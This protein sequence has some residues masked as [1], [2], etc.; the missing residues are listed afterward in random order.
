MRQ[1]LSAHALVFTIAFS[2]L[3]AFQ[4]AS[5]IATLRSIEP[6]YVVLAQIL[7]FSLPVMVVSLAAYCFVEMAIYD[8]PEH[9]IPRSGGK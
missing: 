6:G 5:H 9:P 8:K 7:M 2:Y 4:I 3:L 1:S